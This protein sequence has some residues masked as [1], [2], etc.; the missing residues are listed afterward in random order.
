MIFCYFLTGST[1]DERADAVL[2]TPEMPEIDQ[3]STTTASPLANQAHKS[4]SSIHSSKRKEPDTP[5]KLKLKRRLD[6]VTETKTTMIRKYKKRV[7]MLQSAV[8]FQKIH[9]IKYL[10]QDINR[11]KNT[12]A[13]K[14]AIIKSLQS[15]VANTVVTEQMNTIKKVKNSRRN[16]RRAAKTKSQAVA[17]TA[18]QS[19]GL[20][21]NLK[22]LSDN[23]AEIHQL[24]NENQCLKETVE[25][26]KQG[27]LSTTN[28]QKAGKDSVIKQECLCTMRSPTMSPQRTFQY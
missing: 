13:K 6:F 4:G 2:Q 1:D 8:D 21:T 20:V 27:E 19:S 16:H 22:Q 9:Q 15:Q 12:I 26:L 10:H 14:N 17:K 5:R 25:E 11:K 23:N 28:F 7:S 18:N 24:E 3:S